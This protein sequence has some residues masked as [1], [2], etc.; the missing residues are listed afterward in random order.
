V[1]QHR[2]AHHALGLADARRLVP[3]RAVAGRPFDHLDLL[4]ALGD[5]REQQVA[6]LDLAGLGAGMLDDR[7][8]ARVGADAAHRQLLRNRLDEGLDRIGGNAGGARRTVE[9]GADPALDAQRRMVD[10]DRDALEA[11]RAVDPLDREL[12]VEAGAEV[13]RLERAWVALHLAAAEH[14]VHPGAR[15]QIVE[16]HGVGD[17]RRDLARLV[18]RDARA[19]EDAGEAVALPDRRRQLDARPLG[20]V[21]ERLDRAGRGDAL[22]GIAAQAER[23][24]AERADLLLV[25]GAHRRFG[26]EADR[27]EIGRHHAGGGAEPQAGEQAAEPFARSDPRAEVDDEVG[28]GEPVDRI[29]D[30]AVDQPADR[31]EAVRPGD[32][33]RAPASAARVALC[34]KILAVAAEQCPPP[35]FEHRLS[36]CPDE[37]IFGSGR[38]QSARP[39]LKS[40]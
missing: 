9:A 1:A 14:Q 4:A 8:E 40:N 11:E 5:A 34:R 37:T 17:H 15:A 36:I 20:R 18:A 23:R 19:F 25:R 38:N 33:E 30:R 16:R 10:R 29:A 7:V 39:W 13:E 2:L 26:D 3:L 31:G 21:G 32:D 6:D 28:A 27:L 12:E 22:A 24:D 35:L